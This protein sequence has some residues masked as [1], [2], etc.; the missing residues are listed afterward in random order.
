M[1]VTISLK[2][3]DMAFARKAKMTAAGQGLT[4]KQFILSAIER[5]LPADI[6]E[7]V[8]AV[9]RAGAHARRGGRR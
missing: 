1:T 5:A 7:R 3:V 6:D 2:K 8:A 4:L 9:E